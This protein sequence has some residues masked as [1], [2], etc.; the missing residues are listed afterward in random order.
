MA[1]STLL[2]D[3]A[4]IA[5]F[6]VWIAAAFGVMVHVAAAKNSKLPYEARQAAVGKARAL[7]IIP[8]VCFALILPVGIELTGAINVYPLSPGLK[9]LFW[10]GI[11]ASS[12][13]SIS[14]YCK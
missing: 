12:D 9:I 2:W 7:D 8:R 13:S 1:N 6:V 14:I 11:G 4:H 10:S 3:Y 5:L